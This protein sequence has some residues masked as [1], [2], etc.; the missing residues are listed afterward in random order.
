MSPYGQ[1]SH[2]WT[3]VLMLEYTACPWSKDGIMTHA[4]LVEMA[5]CFLELLQKVTVQSVRQLTVSVG[6]SSPL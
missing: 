1:I 4:H 2:S 5:K 3:D 6:K